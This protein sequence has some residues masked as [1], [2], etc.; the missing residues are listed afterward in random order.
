MQYALFEVAE[1]K[2]VLVS[3][4]EHKS[5]YDHRNNLAS[6]NDLPPVAESEPMYLCYGSYMA[7]PGVTAEKA[8]EDL[9]EAQDHYLGYIEDN[10]CHKISFHS[11]EAHSTVK[12]GRSFYIPFAALLQASPEV[13]EAIGKR[14]QAVTSF[15]RYEHQ[16][17]PPTN[18]LNRPG[19]IAIKGIEKRTK[20]TTVT[21]QNWKSFVNE[22]RVMR[23]GTT[24]Y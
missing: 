22:A 23:N 13:I 1:G 12:R 11:V 6:F 16:M 9:L 8:L 5:L 2:L 21:L 3:A 14:H 18:V 19:I 20:G 15:L 17:D 7:N 10:L 24:I 4:T